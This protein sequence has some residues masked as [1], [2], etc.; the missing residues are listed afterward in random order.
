M[1]AGL[2][3]EANQLI[4]RA[5]RAAPNVEE[6]RYWQDLQRQLTPTP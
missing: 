5:A 4:E 3:V 1:R 6:A 2:M